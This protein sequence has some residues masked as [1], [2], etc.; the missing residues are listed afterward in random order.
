MALEGDIPAEPQ[1]DSARR[2]GPSPRRGSGAAC[3]VPPEVLGCG[4]AAEP[5]EVPGGAPVVRCG[6]AGWSPRGVAARRARDGCAVRPSL[7][8]LAAHLKASPE[9][10]EELG[11]TEGLPS[12]RLSPR[13]TV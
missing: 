8:E 7:E 4:P 11:R 3:G 1:A 9:K 5:R 10:L 12:R 6:E 13:G 2:S